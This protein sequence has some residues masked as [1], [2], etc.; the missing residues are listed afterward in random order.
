MEL[1]DPCNGNPDTNL[2]V[3]SPKLL[4]EVGVVG[5]ACCWA[6]GKALHHIVAVKPSPDVARGVPAPDQES[7]QPK[8]LGPGH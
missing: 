7:D 2:P 3:G 4:P 8:Q 6:F 5:M 1:P